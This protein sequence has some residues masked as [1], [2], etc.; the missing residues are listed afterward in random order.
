MIKIKEHR[1]L[2]ELYE[3]LTKGDETLVEDVLPQKIEDYHDK[4]KCYLKELLEEIKA[5]E[6]TFE[7]LH[8]GEQK[9]QIE[10]DLKDLKKDLYCSI[11][12]ILELFHYFRTLESL[13]DRHLEQALSIP[14]KLFYE[15]LLELKCGGK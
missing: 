4:V 8:E 10:Q 7:S 1:E 2:K 6:E 9:E 12:E 13:S 14:L 5:N 3:K 15:L 11:A